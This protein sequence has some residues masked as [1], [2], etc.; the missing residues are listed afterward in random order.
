MGYIRETGKKRLHSLTVTLAGLLCVVILV[1]L[2]TDVV[3]ATEI[4]TVTA[5]SANIRAES[6]TSSNVVASVVNGDKL[7]IIDETTG[8]DGKVW[9]KVVV[10][11]NTT[12]YIRSDLLEKTEEAEN[13]G[14][15]ANLEGVSEVQPVSASVVR[16]QVR[17]RT[18]S[19]TNSSIVT[20]VQR[21]AV[22]TVQGTKPGNGDEVWYLV[23]FV[24]DGA[25]VKGYVRSDFVT[26]SGEL[27]PVV[28]TPTEVP[29]DVEE[30]VPEVPAEEPKNYETQKED[31]KWWLIDNGTNLRY[32]L[33]T[34]ITNAEQNAN[35]LE[36]VQKQVSK[37]NGI[38]IFLSILV[39]VMVLG[40]TLL[41]FK[42]R[43][44]KEDEGFDEI[45]V[46]R[47]SGGGSGTRPTRPAGNANRQMNRP[48]GARPSG[49]SGTRP[50]N[51][52]GSRPAAGNG[53][54][55]PASRPA[56]AGARPAAGNTGAKASGAKPVAKPENARPANAKPANAG[57]GNKTDN[58]PKAHVK[59]F[60]SDDEFEFEFLNW[61]GEEDK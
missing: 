54:G 37:Q 61:D 60:M 16:D 19:T 27:L 31:D 33:P 46:R 15:V 57:G 38:I 51:G 1:L 42:I 9:Y 22:L 21:D 18:D 47:S 13:T 10:D 59:N 7:E 34:L 58:Q 2:Q 53:E 24:A 40:V 26:L 36:K 39:V 29:S 23:S 49:S 3:H 50:A 8:A 12:G 48:S 35:E 30:P 25:E 56:G 17:V 43:D 55:R 32:Q 41:I 52:Q 5:G 20:M 11:A 6:N 4:G 28:D 44:M 45:P 14:A